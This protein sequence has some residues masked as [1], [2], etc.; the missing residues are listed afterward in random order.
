MRFKL[1]LSLSNAHNR[2]LP[3][4]Y[5]YELSSFIYK[6]IANGDKMYADWLH[7]NGFETQGKQFR[8]FTFSNFDIPKYAINKTNERLI[9]Q[10][11]EVSFEIAFLPEKSTEEFV[12]GIF[13]NQHFSIG[14]KI[15][16]VD[17]SIKSIEL[18]PEPNFTMPFEGKTLSPLCVALKNENDKI[19]YISPEHPEFIK[20]LKSNLLTKYEAF[21]GKNLT[22]ETFFAWETKSKPHPKLIKIKTDTAQQTRVKGYLFEFKLFTSPELM[23]IAHNCGLGEKNSMGFGMIGGD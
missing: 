6:T 3:M 23:K 9:I 21:Y 18:I 2:K 4:S 14:D 11:E 17:F 8:L 16:K 13:A 15:S 7:K 12:K 19:D 22:S 10:S 20:Q 1:S 5:Q